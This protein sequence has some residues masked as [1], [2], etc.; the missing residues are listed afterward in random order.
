M[1]LILFFGDTNVLLILFLFS[2]STLLTNANTSLHLLLT[3]ELLWIMLYAV[4]L[5]IGMTYD[6]LNILSLTFFFLIFSAVEFGVGLVLMLIQNLLT[7]SL[8]LDTAGSVQSKYTTGV[9]R[10]LFLNKLNWKF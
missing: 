1:N 10:G 6:N 2:F 5:L 8:N 3:A 9:T 7:R 4:A